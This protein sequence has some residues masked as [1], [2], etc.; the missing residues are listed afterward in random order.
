MFYSYLTYYKCADDFKSVKSRFYWYFKY[1]LVST[2]KA[3]LKLGGRGKVF[4]RYGLD[5]KC[6]DSK[7]KEINFIKEKELKKLK[8]TF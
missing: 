3:K 6:L 2:I 4:K 8:R 5:I 7:G 1:S